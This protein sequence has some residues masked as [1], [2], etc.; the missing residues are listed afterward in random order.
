MWCTVLKGTTYQLL[1]CG[2]GGDNNLQGGRQHEYQ[3][4]ARGL[5]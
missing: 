3:T 4:V 5:V 1:V 2:G